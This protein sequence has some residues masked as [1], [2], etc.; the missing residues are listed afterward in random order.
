METIESKYDQQARDAGVYIVCSCG[1]DSI[2]ND[3]GA[4]MVQKSFNGDLAYVDS[5]VT[6]HGS[7]VSLMC[8]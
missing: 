5:Y 3:M 7:N 1:F 8:F 2:P 4:L 6:L